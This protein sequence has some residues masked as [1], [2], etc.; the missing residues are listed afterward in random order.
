MGVRGRAASRSPG[1]RRY[2]NFAGQRSTKG[3]GAVLADADEAGLIGEDDR[4]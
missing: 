1:R 2:E 3:L 4:L